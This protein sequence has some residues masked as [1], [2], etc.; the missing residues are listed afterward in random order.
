VSASS[1]IPAHVAAVG[2][3]VAS[4]V[5]E[6]IDAVFLAFLWL[7]WNTPIG[8][9]VCITLGVLTARK[10]QRSIFNWVLVGA[11]NG[12]IPVL[13]PILMIVAYFFYPPPAPSSRRGYH[14]PG[15]VGRGAGGAGSSSTKR[16]GGGPRDRR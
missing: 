2:G 3:V 13:G 15:S 10:T 5:G 11:I 12:I 14:P 9:I 1:P 8:V 6:V 4:S 16:R 7:Q